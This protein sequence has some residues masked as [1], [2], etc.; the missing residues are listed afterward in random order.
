MEGFGLP[1]LE[2]MECGTP[3]LASNCEALREVVQS[4]GHYFDPD[5]VDTLA[6]MLI[7]AATDSLSDRESRI[8]IGRERAGQLTWEQ[9]AAQT[10]AVYRDLLA[11]HVP[12]K[13]A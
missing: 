12:R 13:V 8:E 9:T 5:D 2:A 11:H 3:V 7:A 4:A 6:E 1:A 10:V